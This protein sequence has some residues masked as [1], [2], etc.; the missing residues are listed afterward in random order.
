MN[1]GTTT[2]FPRN[3][4]ATAVGQICH[5]VGGG[6]PSTEREDFWTSGTPWITSADLFG[7][8]DVRPRRQVTNEAIR[9]SATNRVPAGSVIVATRVGLGKVG[10]APTDICFSQDCHGLVFDHS[11]ISP[12]FLTYFLQVAVQEF[13]HVSRGTTIAGVTKKQLVELPVWLPPLPEQRRIVAEIEKHF[14]RLDAA[15]ASLRR[16]RVNLKRYRASVLRAACEGRL[17]PTEAELA[18]Q[19]GRQ[20]EPASVL[21]ERTLKER[22]ARWGAQP[23]R[24]GAYRE[25]Q[26]PDTSNFPPLPEGWTWATLGQISEIQGGIQKQ[27]KRA[28][29]SH[30]FPFLQVA[31]VFRGRLDLGQI[32]SIELFGGE[33]DKLRLEPGDLLIVEGNGSVSEIGRM[34]IW[35]GSIPNCVHQNHIIRARMLGGLFPQFASAYW[36]S[37]EGTAR[38]VGVA[39][40]TSGLYTLSV[41]KI[42]VLPVPLPPLVEQQRIVAEVER[43]LSVI[44]A[45]ENVVV[46]NL[47]RAER[48]RQAILQRAFQGK[49]VPQDP[50]DEPA[51]VLLERIRQER[52]QAEETSATRRRRSK[53]QE[54]P[55]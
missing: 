41:S 34:A 31:N 53:T 30:A 51:S 16:A 20:Y 21:L 27:P 49:L 35:D 43:H 4:A 48:L 18:H 29:R 52:E 45:A 11:C 13:K 36:N 26:P 8:A 55:V 15:V 23:G 17:V 7:I 1:R 22:R 47:K 32:H 24:R 28:P 38:V 10:L 33:L 9:S 6:T 25:P 42:S 3:W 12:L 5:V 50:S 54:V 40:S 39:A 14:T 19:E 2:V 37:P 46:A 44:Q